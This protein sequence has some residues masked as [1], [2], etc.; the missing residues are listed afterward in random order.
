MIYGGVTEIE[1]QT[2]CL[3]LMKETIF[4]S[5]IGTLT[6]SL[7]HYLNSFQ[8]SISPSPGNL[9]HSIQGSHLSKLSQKNKLLD[10]IQ[11][12]Q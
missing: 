5:Q 3:F 9:D 8:F 10:S 2:L 12:F 7:I 1:I 11:I 4:K 6:F